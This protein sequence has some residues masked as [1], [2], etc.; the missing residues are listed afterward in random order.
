LTNAHPAA[1]NRIEIEIKSTSNI[2]HLC[3]MYQRYFVAGLGQRARQFLF[4]CPPE[5]PVAGN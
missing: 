2:F 1:K 4:L 3:D 5:M